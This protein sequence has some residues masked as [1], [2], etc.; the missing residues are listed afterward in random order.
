MAGPRVTVHYPPGYGM[1]ILGFIIPYPPAPVLWILAAVDI[2]FTVWIWRR[3]S[4]LR[5]LPIGIVVSAYLT[6]VG[7]ASIGPF[8]FVLL[9]LQVGLLVVRWLHKTP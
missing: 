4:I 9:C 8:F 7:L 3:Q 1:H 5:L 6:L 2:G